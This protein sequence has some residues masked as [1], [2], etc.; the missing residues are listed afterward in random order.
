MNKTLSILTSF[1]I[2]IS[3]ST[4]ALAQLSSRK[5]DSLVADALVKFKVAGASVAVV[6][7]G[8]V[9]PMVDSLVKLD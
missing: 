6:K 8:K 5:I 7:D 1:L 4:P 9:I 3:L 2:V